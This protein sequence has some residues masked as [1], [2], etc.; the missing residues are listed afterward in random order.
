MK[1]LIILSSI[2]CL[3]LYA[4]GSDETPN[5]LDY[6]SLCAVTGMHFFDINGSATGKWNEPNINNG[7]VIVFPN[8]SSGFVTVLSQNNIIERI[9]LI[10]A[11]CVHDTTNM[12][13]PNLSLDLAYDVTDLAEKQVVDDSMIPSDSQFLYDFSPAGKGMFRLFYQFQSGA[14]H[15]TNIYIDPSTTNFPNLD[16]I[17]DECG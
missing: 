15:W 17:D 6:A 3:G 13:I 5:S 7:N 11:E 2:F 4:C 1:Q 16:F 9:W 12:N 14:I 8:P 10:P